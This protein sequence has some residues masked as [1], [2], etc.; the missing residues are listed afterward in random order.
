MYS[1]PFVSR[2]R[3]NLLCIC[4]VGISKEYFRFWGALCALFANKSSIA[5]LGVLHKTSPYGRMV[6][7]NSLRGSNKPRNGAQN[8]LRESIEFLREANKPRNGAQNVLRHTENFLRETRNHSNVTQN[9]LRH[10]E[11]FLRETNYRSN[12]TQRHTFRDKYF[13]NHIVKGTVFGIPVYILLYWCLHKTG[14]TNHIFSN[15]YNSRSNLD[16]DFTSKARNTSIT[17]AF[18]KTMPMVESKSNNIHA[19]CQP[20]TIFKCMKNH[21]HSRICSRQLNHKLRDREPSRISLKKVMSLLRRRKLRKRQKKMI[22]KRTP[23]SSVLYSIRRRKLRKRQKKMIIKRTP[24]SSV[25]Y[26]TL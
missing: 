4:H 9:V 21:R 1:I 14:Q 24:V 10:T 16:G 17:N 22:I 7:F 12:A 6:S 3:H 8:L 13:E 15:I 20:I 11:N 19:S 5:S 2:T 26:S 18:E 23:V 25:L